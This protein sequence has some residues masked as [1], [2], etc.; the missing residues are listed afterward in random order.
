MTP[1][2]AEDVA[3]VGAINGCAIR[4]PL[5]GGLAE[6]WSRR[7]LPSTRLVP[8]RDPAVALAILSEVFTPVCGP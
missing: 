2:L 7:E 6:R 1:D 5:G 4:A 8:P 3:A